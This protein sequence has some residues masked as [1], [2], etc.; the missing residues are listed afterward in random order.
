V[1]AADEKTILARATNSRYIRSS[2]GALRA[3][4]AAS[5]WDRFGHSSVVEKEGLEGVFERSQ[6]A[7]IRNSMM[8]K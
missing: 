3:L 8:A 1:A 5:G 6:R 4:A 7:A 2:R